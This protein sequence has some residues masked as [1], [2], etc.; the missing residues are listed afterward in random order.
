MPF[1]HAIWQY[2]YGFTAG[3]PE[4]E[5]FNYYVAMKVQYAVESAGKDPKTAAVEADTLKQ[6]GLPVTESVPLSERFTN[7]LNNTEKSKVQMVY[8]KISLYS[9]AEAVKTA[10]N[11]TRNEDLAALMEWHC[12]SIQYYEDPYSIPTNRLPA[13]FYSPEGL[14]C[15]VGGFINNWAIEKQ[16]HWVNLRPDA[17]KRGMSKGA[18]ILFDQATAFTKYGPVVFLALGVG[19]AAFLLAMAMKIMGLL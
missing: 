5:L 4:A 14:W 9:I 10:R 12:K 11:M 1:E 7:M 17:V 3:A 15:H 18:Q 6:A 13:A 16:W 19:G 8:G 2:A